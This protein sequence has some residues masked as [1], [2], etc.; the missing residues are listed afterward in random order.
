MLWRNV[1]SFSQT[2]FYHKKVHIKWD[3]VISSSLRLLMKV[4]IWYRCQNRTESY[5]HH[6]VEQLGTYKNTEQKEGCS[7][8]LYI[9]RNEWVPIYLTKTTQEN[10]Q[11]H[12]QH[13]ERWPRGIVTKQVITSKP[14]IF[15]ERNFA[16]ILSKAP[17]NK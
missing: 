16:S 8:N 3:V 13:G 5:Y 14:L 11:L 2:Y 15:S 4:W 6:D 12:I 17:Q 9:A 10:V 1:F 7:C